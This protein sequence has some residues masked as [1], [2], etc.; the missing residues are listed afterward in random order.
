MELTNDIK[1]G[2]GIKCV[3]CNNI[4]K[5]RNY[6]TAKYCSSNCNEVA[7]KRRYLK[8]LKEKCA[9]C[10]IK[11]DLEFHHIDENKNNNKDC[12]IMILCCEHHEVITSYNFA[13]KN[14]KKLS[15]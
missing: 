9:I 1:K 12:N 2:E 15:V 3:S 8:K 6:G 14:I 13:K 5:P 4:F 11:E 7:R 10:P